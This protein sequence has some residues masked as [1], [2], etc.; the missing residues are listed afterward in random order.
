MSAPLDAPAEED[1]TGEKEI[2]MTQFKDGDKVLAY[3]GPLIYEAKIQKAELRKNEWKYFVHYL[4]WSK[5]WD[6]W[7]GEERLLPLNEENLEK[8]KHLVN[9]QAADKRGKGRMGQGKP[10]GATSTATKGRKR[11]SEEK[12][13]E[14]NSLKFSLPAALKKLLIED[15]E[16]VTQGSK[17]AKLPKSPSVEEIL[18]KYLETKTKPGDSLVEIL[19]GLRSYFDKALPLM[20]LYKEERKQHVEVFANNTSTPSAVY[21]AEHFLR[22]FVKLPELLQ[23]VNMEEEAAS[24]LQ[25]KLMDLLKFI[26]KNQSTFFHANADGLKFENK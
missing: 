1:T 7:I 19:N 11:K 18:Q 24:Q 5:N 25:Q 8:Q 21:G 22:L 6:E 20:L 23:Y 9:T 10:K 14:D 3:H 26:Q 12:D 2:A 17:L 16:L 4:G 15:C 13:G